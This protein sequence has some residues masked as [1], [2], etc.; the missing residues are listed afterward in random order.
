ML[1]ENEKPPWPPP[2]CSNAQTRGTWTECFHWPGTASMMHDCGARAAP[3][4]F[5]TFPS[6]T[7]QNNNEKW[8]KPRF[9]R[10][11]DWIQE[12]FQGSCSIFS[13][14]QF[15]QIQWYFDDTSQHEQRRC[16]NHEILKI[17]QT[18]KLTFKSCFRGHTG[19]RFLKKP[20]SANR[21]G[22]ILYNNSRVG[23]KGAKWSLH[24]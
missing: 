2:F 14:K 9:S 16:N 13:S 23:T 21:S 24:L 11:C 5:S 19:R 20:S 7:L 6:H 10:Q 3:A 17:A 8:R 12:W 1:S 18:V 22:L 4:H 15:V